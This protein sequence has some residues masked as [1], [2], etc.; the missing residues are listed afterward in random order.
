M[1]RGIIFV[2]PILVI[3]WVNISCSV[4]IEN[5]NTDI[6][7]KLAKDFQKI[8][9]KKQFAVLYIPNKNAV[10]GKVDYRPTYP[11]VVKSVVYPPI[12]EE[13][14]K[15]KSYPFTYS[16]MTPD[17]GG[18]SFGKYLGRN[19]VQN[20][21]TEDLALNLVFPMMKNWFHTANMGQVSRV[22]LYSYFLPCPDCTNIIQNFLNANKGVSLYIGF[23][24]LLGGYPNETPAD[25]RAR[26]FKLQNIIKNRGFLYD[27]GCNIFKKRRRRDLDDIC[28]LQMSAGIFSLLLNFSD[29]TASV[30]ID[31]LSNATVYLKDKNNNVLESRA[32]SDIEIKHVSFAD[33]YMTEGHYAVLHKEEKKIKLQTEPWKQCG[34]ARNVMYHLPDNY[35]ETNIQLHILDGSPSVC[36]QSKNFDIMKNDKIL[37][38]GLNQTYSPIEITNAHVRQ[39]T[40]SGSRNTRCF[41][42]SRLSKRFS[43][44]F[45]AKFTVCYSNSTC[46]YGGLYENASPFWTPETCYCGKCYGSEKNLIGSAGLAHDV[47]TSQFLLLLANFLHLVFAY[48][49]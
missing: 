37:I 39:F 42:F 12:T 36:L 40:V 17:Y 47:I 19:T 44:G 23:S 49:R 33:I 45:R 30:L 32:V 25:A 31:G 13:N 20:I 3:W 8:R 43:R 1:S 5:D 35:G 24:Q 46:T 7:K 11:N 16:G 4:S 27:L 21:H 41:S 9:D 6:L 15:S 10:N 34:F 18:K 29:G 48:V 26:K 38:E 14:K 2:L 22:Y 28:N